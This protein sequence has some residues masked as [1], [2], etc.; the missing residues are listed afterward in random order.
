LTVANATKKEVYS[1][2]LEMTADEA[3]T[4]LQIMDSIG[5][6]Q[7]SARRYADDIGRALHAVGI[8]PSKH[9]ISGNQSAIYFED[10]PA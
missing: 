5:G 2:A 7:L 9:P 3:Q 8:R 6:R 1:V 4:L 10:V